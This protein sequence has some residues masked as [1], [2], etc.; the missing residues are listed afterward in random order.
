M[1][2]LLE[3]SIWHSFCHALGHSI[4]YSVT[5][6]P[7]V[8]AH[9]LDFKFRNEFY[10]ISLHL[11]GSMNHHQSFLIFADLSIHVHPSIS[12]SHHLSNYFA[13]LLLYERIIHTY[14]YIYTSTSTPVPIPTSILL[15]ISFISWC[16]RTCMSIQLSMNRSLFSKI[17]T[18]HS[19]L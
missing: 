10:S 18:I 9:P 7:Q 3:S 13:S 5:L 4:C 11:T 19:V 17:Q 8:L 14:V 6:A 2:Y 15:S 12:A 16:I 1:A